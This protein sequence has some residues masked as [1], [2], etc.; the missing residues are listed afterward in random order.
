MAASTPGARAMPI[1]RAMPRRAPLKTARYAR[2][3]AHAA[4]RKEETLREP[5]RGTTIR[6][7]PR[8]NEPRCLSAP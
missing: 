4:R 1:K 6:L 7:P 3:C 5:R 8:A 2:V